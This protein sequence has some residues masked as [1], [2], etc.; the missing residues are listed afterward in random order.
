MATRLKMAD[1]QTEMADLKGLVSQLVAVVGQQR[2][3]APAPAAPAVAAPAAPVTRR[4]PKGWNDAVG[5]VISAD[6]GLV[7][8]PGKTKKGTYVVVK[9]RC[10]ETGL[11]NG[12]WIQVACWGGQTLPRV[13]SG[14]FNGVI[15]SEAR[16]LV[17]AAAEYV[18]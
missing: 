7:A 18:D 11:G 6:G 14:E 2:Q 5:G 3:A 8:I 9:A 13:L 17:A 1:L 16:A 12:R 4:I 10:G 15:S